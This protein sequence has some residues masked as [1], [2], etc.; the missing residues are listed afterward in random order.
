MKECEYQTRG[1]ILSV[2]DPVGDT[3]LQA[4]RKEKFYPLLRPKDFD[5]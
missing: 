2:M 5:H 4:K 1:G 3:L